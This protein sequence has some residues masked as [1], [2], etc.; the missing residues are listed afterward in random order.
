MTFMGVFYQGDGDSGFGIITDLTYSDKIQL[1]GL[2][3][4]YLL[5]K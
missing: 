3:A 2:P 1:K 4:D 5:D